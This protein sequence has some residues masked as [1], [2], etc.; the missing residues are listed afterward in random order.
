MAA[1]R[2]AM[3]LALSEAEMAA[4]SAI[5]R[6]RTE[7]ANRI[8]RARMLLAYRDEPSFFAVALVGACTIRR[9]TAVS[10]G[11][12]WPAVRS[13]R[14]T[15]GH[16]PGGSRRS[17]P[18]PR[19]LWLISPAAR[20]RS[21]AICTNCGQRGFSLAMCASMGRPRATP[22]LAGWPRASCAT[23]VAVPD[24]GMNF[25]GQKIDAGEQRYRAMT[26]I[27][28]IARETLMC[29]RRG[30]QVWRRIGDRRMPGFSS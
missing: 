23:A 4:L 14:L 13:R 12:R 16:A 6:S 9:S 27:F 19:P 2:Q 7:P 1:W 26:L 11:G 10:S 17:P 21:S 5:D 3:E 22:A 8:E 15:T 20:P 30:R 29:A 25:P 28:V 18:R 24:Q